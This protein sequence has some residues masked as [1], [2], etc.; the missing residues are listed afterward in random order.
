MVLIPWMKIGL[1][2]ITLFCVMHIWMFRYSR[3][4]INKLWRWYICDKIVHP[5][6]VHTSMWYVLCAFTG[7]FHVSYDVSKYNACHSHRG[8][9]PAAARAGVHFRTTRWT[10]G[11]TG[12][13]GLIGKRYLWIPAQECLHIMLCYVWVVYDVFIYGLLVVTRKYFY[14]HWGTYM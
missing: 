1:I 8:L 13:G 6:R 12:P 5:R 3:W 2:W 9:I 11:G 7:E 14:L 4:L 10:L